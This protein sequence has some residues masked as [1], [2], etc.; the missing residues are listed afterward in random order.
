M[1]RSAVAC[2]MCCV[3]E[4]IVLHISQITEDDVIVM[5]AGGL[6]KH[7]T[8]TGNAASIWQVQQTW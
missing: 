1:I 7:A 5:S 2:E 3:L 6:K 4:C 8:I